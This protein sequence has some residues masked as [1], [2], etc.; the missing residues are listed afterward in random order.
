[1]RAVK[2]KLSILLL[3]VAYFVVDSWWSIMHSNV[4]VGWPNVT[5]VICFVP[6]LYLTFVKPRIA[7]IA[8][9]IYLVLG[10]VTLISLE[11]GISR[12]WIG[13]GSLQIPLGNSICLILLFLFVGFN[14]SFLMEWYLDYKES[15]QKR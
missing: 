9:I 1:M 5:A 14:L 10:V 6:V 2:I 13:I 7:V 11:P 3:I 15:K 8:A 4:R 12:S